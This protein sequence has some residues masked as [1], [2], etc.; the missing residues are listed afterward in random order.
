MP[1]EKSDDTNMGALAPKIAAWKIHKDFFGSGPRYSFVYS[2]DTAV[3][4]GRGRARRK[5]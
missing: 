4:P 2:L 3:S 5:D 1:E